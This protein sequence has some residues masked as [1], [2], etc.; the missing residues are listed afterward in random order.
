[1]PF[2][3]IAP[4]FIAK[5]QLHVLRI[6]AQ[7]KDPQQLEKLFPEVLNLLHERISALSNQKIPL[8]ELLVT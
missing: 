1:M 4:S 5:T 3:L 8:T 7:Q 6:L 2:A